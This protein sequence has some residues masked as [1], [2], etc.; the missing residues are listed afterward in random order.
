MSR[1]FP[2]ATFTVYNTLI[3]VVPC[4]ISTF[5]GLLFPLCYQTLVQV[6]SSP[7]WVSSQQFVFPCSCSTW[8][9]FVFLFYFN[10][11]NSIASFTL[12]KWL[13]N[14]KKKIKESQLPAC[15]NQTS[16]PPLFKRA[17]KYHQRISWQNDQVI[18]GLLLSPI[19]TCILKT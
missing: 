14:E 9:S 5:F 3:S 7:L 13:I 4:G 6:V 15:E 2:V 19:A 18:N 11:F 10:N 12:A 8:S 1:P 17:F 16:Q